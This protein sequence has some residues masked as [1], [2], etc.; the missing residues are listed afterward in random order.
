MSLLFY[1]DKHYK[2]VPLSIYSP[3][4]QMDLSEFASNLSD[5]KIS[6]KFSK[7]GFDLIDNTEQIVSPFG[8]SG[9]EDITSD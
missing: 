2:I 7:D 4:E 3:A 1:S 5:G 9:L 8:S 6:L